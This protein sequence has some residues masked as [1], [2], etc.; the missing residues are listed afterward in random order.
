MEVRGLSSCTPTNIL[1]EITLMGHISHCT[2][3]S[4]LY[5]AAHTVYER[6]SQCA[7]V[8]SEIS[9]T[10]CEDSF[11]SLLKSNVQLT[12]TSTKKVAGTTAEK[13]VQNWCIR[14]E[15]AKRT[16]EAATQRILRTVTNLSLSRRFRT[17]DRQLRYRRISS[18][19]YT[20]NAQS[21]VISK[22]GN[23]YCQFF[24]LLFGW[25]RAFPMPKN[26]CAHETLSLLFKRDGVPN[27]M[28]MDGSKE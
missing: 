17:N 3:N 7:S 24:S 15:A 9:P 19:M 1:E 28:I 16:A 27:T 2:P 12:A 18:D 23:K 4:S 13:L 6:R 22:I 8:L 20:D 10:L 11:L 21:V 14:L 25:V 5:D 26:S